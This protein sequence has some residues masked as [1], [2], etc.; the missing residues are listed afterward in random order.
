MIN[1]KRKEKKRTP[2]RCTI[3]SVSAKLMGSTNFNRLKRLQTTNLTQ[4]QKLINLVGPFLYFLGKKLYLQGGI[5]SHRLL[6]G[7]NFAVTK[8]DGLDKTEN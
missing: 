7:K 8:H 2:Q 3:A 5:L 6:V 4:L 1:E